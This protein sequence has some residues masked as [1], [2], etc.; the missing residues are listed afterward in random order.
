MEHLRQAAACERVFVPPDY[1]EPWHWPLLHLLADR[2]RTLRI[3]DVECGIPLLL[4]FLARSGFEALYGA[5]DSRAR[6]GALEAAREFC[7]L[8]ATSAVIADMAGLDADAI[9]GVLGGKRF[10]VVTRFSATTPPDFA[11]IA[12]LLRGGGL[13]VAE[14]ALDTANDAFE[15]LA[16][17]PDLGFR[18][19]YDGGV[20]I[21]RKRTLGPFEHLLD[22]ARQAQIA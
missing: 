11:L 19:P 18:L 8:S 9:I 20:A 3:L 2:P 12:R 17:F 16:V 5:E 7:A 10:D 1:L 22:R 14:T 6:P 21:F 4:H 13:F 15:T